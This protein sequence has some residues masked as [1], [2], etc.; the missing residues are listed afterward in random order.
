[1]NTAWG[2]YANAMCFAASMSGCKP[3]LVICLCPDLKLMVM[4][5][6]YMKLTK[7]VVPLFY[8]LLTHCN[9]SIPPEY[10]MVDWFLSN[11]SGNNL[12]L[13]VYDDICKRTYFRGRLARSNE[14]RMSTCANSEGR[15]EI[16]YRRVGYNKGNDPWTE[17]RMN[18]DQ[19]LLLR[20]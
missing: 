2:A 8:L 1:M 18:H 20:F 17:A 4:T 19:S 10:G 12:T 16:K 3:A 11:T 5:P 15:A 6:G 7:L 14:V 13:V 9:S